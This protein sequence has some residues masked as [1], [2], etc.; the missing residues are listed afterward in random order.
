MMK[1]RDNASDLRILLLTDTIYPDE[2]GGIQISMYQIYNQFKI[3]HNILHVAKLGILPNKNRI[4]RLPKGYIKLKSGNAQPK[5][6]KLIS[7]KLFQNITQLKFILS[8]AVKHFVQVMLNKSVGIR[9]KIIYFIKYMKKNLI[10]LPELDEYIQKHKINLIV[11]GAINPLCILGYYFKMKYGFKGNSMKKMKFVGIAH[12]LDVLEGDI[13][14]NLNYLLMDRAITRTNY[15]K[16][17][18][19][20][21]YKFP[22]SKFSLVPDGIT[23]SHF[24]GTPPYSEARKMLKIPSN[25]FTIVSIGRLAYRKSFDLVIKAVS[26]ILIERPQLDLC[27]TIVGSGPEKDKLNKLIHHYGLESKISIKSNVSN[28][29]RNKWIAASD[30]FCMVSREIKDKNVEG[31]GIVFLEA[32][33]LGVPVI[34]SYTG[35]IPEAIEENKSGLLINQDDLDSLIEKIL[36]LVENKDVRSKMGRYGQQRVLDTFMIKHTYEKYLK[37]FLDA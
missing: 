18:V 19:V 26:K 10:F 16:S 12:G 35:G 32:N 34:G 36:Y 3:N 9:K 37:A 20:G 22:K 7:T 25:S 33:Y 30:L 2:V 29:D 27:Y 17:L 4:F 28:E 21:K 31:F 8:F 14:R 15:V 24:T 23:K 6:Q 1:I 11:A 5:E 13:D